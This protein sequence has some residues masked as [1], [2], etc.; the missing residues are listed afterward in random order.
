MYFWKSLLH[1]LAYLLSGTDKLYWSCH[2]PGWTSPFS[3][4]LLIGW[5]L[6]LRLFCPPLV[7]LQH[8]S[9]PEGPK[10][11]QS[12]Q[13]G[14]HDS[15]TKKDSPSLLCLDFVTMTTSWGVI[16]HFQ[17]WSTLLACNWLV[18]ARAHRSFP[19]EMLLIS[20]QPGSL[21]WCFLPRD[22]PWYLSLLHF[23]RLFLPIPIVWLGPSYFLHID[24]HC[25][26]TISTTKLVRISSISSSRSLIK[27]LNRSGP[28][29]NLWYTPFLTDLYNLSQLSR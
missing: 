12:I 26:S 29:L 21:H 16:G 14:S 17:S 19:A 18:S 15:W 8:L 25:Q 23:V 9:I 27:Y 6:H 10:N 28:N 1:L 7:F 5:I 20:P 11:E 4:L 2:F 22:S 3:H 13:M 24:S